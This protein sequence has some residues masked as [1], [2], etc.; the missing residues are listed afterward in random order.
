[1]HRMERG[2][3]VRHEFKAFYLGLGLPDP[4]AVWQLEP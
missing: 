1:M 2:P 3:G 4:F